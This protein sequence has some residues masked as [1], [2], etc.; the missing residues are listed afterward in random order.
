MVGWGCHLTVR[1][2]IPHGLLYL[3]E[4]SFAETRGSLGSVSAICQPDSATL[5]A[6]NYN[7]KLG[8]FASFDQNHLY[9]GGA[10]KSLHI[11]GRG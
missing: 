11:T 2:S 1:V 6:C 9:N 3:V 10:Q 7:P 5:H 8:S 4:I